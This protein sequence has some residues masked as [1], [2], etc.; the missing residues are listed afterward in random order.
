MARVSLLGHISQ[1]NVSRHL[2]T[3]KKEGI[4][5]DRRIRNRVIYRLEALSVLDTLE[6]AAEVARLD[7]KRRTEKVKK[8]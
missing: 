4:V 7:V 2:V 3:P 8:L 6:P 5:S 1:S